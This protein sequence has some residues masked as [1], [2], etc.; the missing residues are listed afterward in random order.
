MQ[1]FMKTGDPELFLFQDGGE[2]AWFDWPDLFGVTVCNVEARW[3]I[4]G[5]EEVPLLPV[6]K[7]ELTDARKSAIREFQARYAQTGDF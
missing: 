5:D 3:Y 7:G 2:G 6:W 4:Y 1:A